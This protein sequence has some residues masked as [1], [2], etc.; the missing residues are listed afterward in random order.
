MKTDVYFQIIY[1]TIKRIKSLR[2]NNFKLCH[3]I[4]TIIEQINFD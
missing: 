2:N 3:R 1:V 4:S